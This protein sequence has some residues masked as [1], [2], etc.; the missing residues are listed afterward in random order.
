MNN[1]YVKYIA[2]GSISILAIIGLTHLLD[3]TDILDNNSGKTQTIYE[4]ESTNTLSLQ[5]AKNIV[6]SEL[7][8]TNDESLSMSC[9]LEYNNVSLEYIVTCINNGTTYNYKINS[10]SNEIINVTPTTNVENTTTEETTTND[11]SSNNSSSSSNSSTTT[12]SYIGET[13][14]KTIAL[15]HA[16]VTNVTYTKVELDYDNGI[17]YYEVEFVSGNT[18]YEYEIN[19]KTGAIIKYEK[20]VINNSSNNTTSTTDYIGEAKAKSIALAHANVSS[21]SVSYTKCE[22]DY[23]DNIV[24]YEVEFKVGKMEYEYKINAITGAILEYDVD[25]DD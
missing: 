25:Y 7:N 20:D 19:A 22:L 15:A 12:T 1:K 17:T 18:E 4:S 8:L 11:T 2:G 24:E 3:E 5:S 13:K 23:D 9:E 21:S 6:A 14:A 10:E 16:N